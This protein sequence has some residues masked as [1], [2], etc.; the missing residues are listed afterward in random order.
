MH[1][2]PPRLYQ[3]WRAEN[4]SALWLR[5]GDEPHRPCESLVQAIWRHQRINRDRLLT[6]DG[7]PLRIL[8]PGFLN[9][10]AGPDFRRAVIQVD[11]EPPITGDV[12]VDLESRN[13]HG[14]QH[15]TNQA[16]AHV[17]LHVV[18]HETAQRPPLPTLVLEHCL[19]AP[20]DEL[21][22]WLSPE[23]RDDIPDNCIGQCARFF[24]QFDREHIRELLRQAA[25]VRLQTKAARLT[26]RAR[27]SGWSQALWEELFRALGYK[28]NAW[29]MQRLAELVPSAPPGQ[30]ADAWQARLLGW[31]GLLPHDVP[32][33][34]DES[35]LY[36]KHLWEFWWRERD[37]WN[38]VLLPPAVWRMDGLR[39]SNHPQRRLALASYWLAGGSLVEQLEHWFEQAKAGLP[40]TD[41]LLA[42]LG[43]CPSGFWSKHFTLRSAP[44]TEPQ[45]LIG[46]SRVTDLAMNVVLPWFWA[47]AQAGGNRVLSQRAELLYLAWPKGQDN[48]VL[49]LARNRLLAGCKGL[50]GSTAAE[51][52]GLLQI[53]RDFCD[54]S[55]AL[56]SQCRL[57]ALMASALIQWGIHPN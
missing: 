1:A 24:A 28:H 50:A 44:L 4:R 3:D 34:A 29:P 32:Q 35:R 18:W 33:R 16:F 19:D 30:T 14:H 38:Q 10:E 49:R 31:A 41:E 7:R 57:P 20:L 52:Q 25:L 37:A 39:P 56:C 43:N 22:Q 8:H 47:R 17:V 26:A 13:W 23:G 6:L 45:P 46:E 48:S 40:L 51:Q 54:Q 27:Q 2:L 9:R 12:E 55:D 21:S 5:E 11:N 36:L 42:I 15:D 53:T